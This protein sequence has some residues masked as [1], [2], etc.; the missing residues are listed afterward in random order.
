MFPNS[1]GIGSYGIDIHHDSAGDAGL[2]EPTKPFQISLGALLPT[3]ISNLIA[4]C[5]NLGVTHITNGAYRVHPCEWA[6]GEAAGALAG[7]CAG[8]GVTTQTVWTDPTWLHSYQKFLLGAG[9][10]LFWWSDVPFGHPAYEATQLLGL[11]QVFQGNGR[12]LQFDVDTLLTSAEAQAL[13]AR[14]GITTPLPQPN[15]TR[16]QAAIWLAGQLGL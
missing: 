5:K 8:Q 14:T 11:A 9:I 12:N 6:I 2:F 10:S 3:D 15:M 4:S 7:F 13:A 16:G 1:C